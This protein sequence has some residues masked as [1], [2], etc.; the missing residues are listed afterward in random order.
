MPDVHFARPELLLLLLAVPLVAGLLLWRALW[1][2]GAAGRLVGRP[3]QSRASGIARALKAAMLLAGIA[4]L[5]VAAARPQMGSHSV[6]LPREGADVIIALDVSASM[7]ATDIPPNR[8]DHAKR[9]V[10][11]ILDG[12]QGDRVGLVAFAGNAVLRF[13]LTTDID[14]ARD[15]TKGTAIREGNLRPGTGIGDALK[16][17]SQSF[18]ED[19]TGS[20]LVVLISD[21]EDLGEGAVEAVRDLRDRDIRLYTMGI[22][23]EQGS[24]LPAPDP[25]NQGRVVNRI[26][27]TTGQAAVSRANEQLMRAIA[28]AGRGKFYNGNGDD[29][30]AQLTQDI[31]SLQ[32]TKFE[33]QEGE[34]PVER[35]QW[36]L[37]AG[38]ALIALQLLIPERRWRRRAA[39]TPRAERR[40]AA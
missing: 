7:L 14:A 25:R 22:G 8:F 32:R 21:G 10:G 17:A 4:L 24:T 18:R 40:R 35:Y 2:R 19:S 33:S 9:L 13:P 15:L 27:P 5:A 6:L 37:A 36:F 12:V 3:A 34:I 39:A 1:R 20:R 23:T 29:A 11:Q 30:V 26:D 31:A 16:V 38:L 28:G